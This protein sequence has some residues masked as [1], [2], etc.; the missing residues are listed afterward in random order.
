MFQH[1]LLFRSLSFH[2]FPT[3]ALT[4]GCESCVR[5]YVQ[6]EQ[7]FVEGSGEEGVQEV[8]VNQRQAQD[9]TAETKPG[10]RKANIWAGELFHFGSN[11][12]QVGRKNI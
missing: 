5:V 2:L 9:P 1:F 11:R 4:N 6:S 3:A 12:I 8:L 10:E 7:R